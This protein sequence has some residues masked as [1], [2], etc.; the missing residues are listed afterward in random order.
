MVVAGDAGAF[1]TGRPEEPTIGY[2]RHRCGHERRQS[3]GSFQPL[4]LQRGIPLHLE[5]RLRF[6]KGYLLSP[7]QVG[8]IG[9]SSRALAVALCEPYQRF[10]GPAR[11]LEV[12]A[13]TGAVTRRLGSLLGEKDE[14]DICEIDPD[15]A[16]ILEHDV[17]RHA[18][19]APGVAAGRVRLL[20]SPVQKLTYENRYDFVI[21]G[22]PLTSFELSDLQEVFG[23]IRRC[24][25]PGGVFSYFEY[26][27]LRKTS[28]LFSFGSRR[29]RIRSVSAYLGRNIR[30]H[31]FDRKTVLQNLPP[32]HARHL[33][34][35]T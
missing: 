21:S 25:K 2:S 6:L 27:A 7:A 9:P 26:L 1:R 33:R 3:D 15:F 11:V 19:F 35:S 18:D 12:G 22:L 4:L 31:Q 34:F 24:L 32:A 16:D 30:D 14:L 8:A 23:V 28:R 20:R 5:A 29:A 17:L 13:G 10:S